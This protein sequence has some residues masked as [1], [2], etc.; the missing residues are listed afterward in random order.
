MPRADRPLPGREPR[1]PRRL[2][3][4]TDPDSD[5]QLP[6]GALVTLTPL[7]PA[8]PM[9]VAAAIPAGTGT[10]VGA[11]PHAVQYPSSIVPPHPGWV[12]AGA[13][14]AAVLPS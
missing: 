11:S 2:P 1:L 14:I 7:T 12:H 8:D 13:V 3:V 5:P 9:P 10:D 6:L 4:P